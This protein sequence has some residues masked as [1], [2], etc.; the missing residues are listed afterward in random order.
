ME[1]ETAE[2]VLLQCTSWMPERREINLLGLNPRF[3]S[4]TQ[5]NIIRLLVKYL[6]STRIIHRI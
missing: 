2:H 1:N 5:F 3:N 4:K 6:K